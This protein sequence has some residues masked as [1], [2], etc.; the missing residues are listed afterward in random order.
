MNYIEID[1]SLSE[2]SPFTDI[3]TAKLNEIEFESYQET[4]YG[5]QAYIQ[6][7]LFNEDLLNNAFL[8][9]ENKVDF[10]FK[11]T[12]IKQQNWN[13]KWESSFQPIIIN[14]KC[15]VRAGF[16]QPIDIEF[17][18]IITPKMSFGTGYHSTTF[19]MMNSMFNLDLIDKA[20]LDIGS[21]TGVLSI[22]AEKLGARNILGIDIDNWAFEN[23]KEN[24]KLNNCNRISFE[25]GDV[26]N[27]GNKRF[28]I[29]LANINR[30]T[31]LKEIDTYS[32]L[33]NY[34]GHM[35][36]SGFYTDDESLILSKIEKL[37]LNLQMKKQKDNWL[38]LHLQK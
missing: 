36:L 29:I 7:K 5:L 9:L 2:K 32:A 17:E 31:I 34:R 4:E 26:S 24:K 11:I 20:I 14:E 16:H 12:E 10:S 1:I 33:L 6:K 3:I 19:L 15:I 35:L 30:N 38:L 13:L 37:N 25:I 21:G 27:I 18:I 8:I 22:L 28:D 23:A